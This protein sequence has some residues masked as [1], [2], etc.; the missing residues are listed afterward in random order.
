MF[1]SRLFRAAL[2]PLA[3][4][5]ALVTGESAYAQATPY[6]V[7]AYAVGGSRGDPCAIMYA[8]APAGTPRYTAANGYTLV[9][10]APNRAAAQQFMLLFSKYH[11]NRP[12]G[13]VKLIPC[14]TNAA[15]SRKPTGGVS[16]CT[17]K[18]SKYK[19]LVQKI[20]YPMDKAKYGSC[21][22]YGY[23]RGTK[24]RGMNVRPGYWVY[25][26]DTWYVFSDRTSVRAAR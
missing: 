25:A 1:A 26:I 17:Y 21:Y 23:W 18:L 13:I 22:E 14:S 3:L 24:W 11:N 6:N 4:T 2:A 8:I 9:R 7:F 12:D 20:H 15:T 16:L 10:T 5:A 19:G